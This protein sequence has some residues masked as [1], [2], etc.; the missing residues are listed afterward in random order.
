MSAEITYWAGRG[1]AVASPYSA[2]LSETRS[3]S[4]SSAQSGSTPD[5]SGLVSIVCT[6]AALRFAYGASPTADAS[7]AYVGVGER[8]WLTAHPGWKLAMVNA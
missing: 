2:I 8:I 3:V 6:S 1:D 4:A 7:G 5:G